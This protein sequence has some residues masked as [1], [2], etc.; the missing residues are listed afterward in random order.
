MCAGSHALHTGARRPGPA[1]GCVW[2]VAHTLLI[3]TR[4]AASVAP[5]P[6]WTLER[7][8]A[9]DEHTLARVAAARTGLRT[10]FMRVVTRTSVWLTALLLLLAAFGEGGFLKGAAIGGVAA[11]L[12]AVLAQAIKYAVRRARPS[13]LY[14]VARSLDR[15]SFPSGHSSTAFALAAASLFVAPALF[16]VILLAAVVVAFSRVYLGV[17]YPSDVLTGALVGVVVGAATFGSGL[18]NT[19]ATVTLLFLGGLGG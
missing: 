16:P 4:V 19:A 11:G 3:A 10:A 14:C 15:Y 12:T 5:S 13:A 7:I 1:W 17:H 8:A 18:A 6:R 9:L 2:D